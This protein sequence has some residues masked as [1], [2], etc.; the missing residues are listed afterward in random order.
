MKMKKFVVGKNCQ[1]KCGWSPR[2]PTETMYEFGIID[3]ELCTACVGICGRLLVQFQKLLAAV[4]GRCY[5]N[6]YLLILIGMHCFSD[7]NKTMEKVAEKIGNKR[8]K[9]IIT[10]VR[11]AA[12]TEQFINLTFFRNFFSAFFLFFS[13]FCCML[14]CVHRMR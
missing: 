9:R 3:I 10:I 6:R 7:N 12:R 14:C 1:E 8:G 5:W 2:S 11:C 4:A 13:A